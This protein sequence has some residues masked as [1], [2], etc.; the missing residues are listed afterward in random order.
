MG[1]KNLSKKTWLSRN[2]HNDQPL[3]KGKSNPGTQII[4][5]N[6]PPMSSLLHLYNGLQWGWYVINWVLINID[7]SEPKWKYPTVQL[8][9]L[10]IHRSKDQVKKITSYLAWMACYITSKTKIKITASGYIAGL[11]GQFL[12]ITSNGF[13]LNSKLTFYGV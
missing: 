2:V 8:I 4:N 9:R 10:K 5:I 6:S 3:V 12:K 7:F 1:P 11:T 13:D